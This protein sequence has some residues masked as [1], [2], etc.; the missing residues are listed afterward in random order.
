MNDKKWIEFIRDEELQHIKE[1]LS[2]NKIKKI[3]EIGG[4]DGYHA[5]RF[6]DWG[7][8][9]ISIDMNP[10]STYFDVKKMDATDLQF[11]SNSFDLVFSSHVIAHIQDKKLVFNEINRVVKNKGLIIHIVPSNWWSL[12]TNFWYY[13]LL[14]KLAYQKIRNRSNSKSW[15]SKNNEILHQGENR[16]IN[17]LINHPL[18][19]EK[20]FIIEIFKFSKNNW[21]KLFTTYENTVIK[22][23][24]GPLV[25][26]GYNILKNHGIKIR[27]KIANVFPC[28]YIFIIEK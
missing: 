27:K 8:D 17:L 20:S 19:T 23:L 15:K 1:I 12:I 18:G 25:Y 24:N 5:K 14:P 16:L 11:E 6:T 21:A 13:I 4:K 7:F 3:L 2:N 22:K 10:V 26:S 28:S 9:V